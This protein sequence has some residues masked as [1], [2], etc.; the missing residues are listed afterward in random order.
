MK[1]RLLFGCIILS[2]LV[3]AQIYWFSKAY[4]ANASEFDHT[5]SVALYNVAD[6]MS[7]QASVEKVSSNYFYVTTNSSFSSKTIDT[8]IQ[9]EFSARNLS[10]DYEIGVYNAKDDSLVHGKYVKADLPAQIKNDYQ[11]SDEVIKNFAVLFPTRKSFLVSQMDVW[12]LVTLVLVLIFS[13]YFPSFFS[14]K[15]STQIRLGKTCLDF[16]N[17]Q[18]KVNDLSYRLTYKENKILQLFFENPNE[19][20]EREVFLE[21]VWQRDGFFT[22]RSMDVFISKIRKYLSNDQSIKI[23]NLRSI[24]YRLH[25]SR[26]KK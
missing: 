25:V 17:Q 21:R 13:S 12:V 5:V 4:H 11:E 18:L 6:T 7:E 24:G 20:I 22:A 9:K 2:L 10:L 15:N 19:V 3:C 14:S 16:H 26:R 8:L 23:E 1:K